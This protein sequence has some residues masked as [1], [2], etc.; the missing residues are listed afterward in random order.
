MATKKKTKYLNAHQAAPGGFK[1][2]NSTWDSL[3]ISVCGAPAKYIR[4]HRRQ[5]RGDTDCAIDDFL[6]ALEVEARRLLKD[7]AREKPAL[8]QFHLTFH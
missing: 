2:R 4:G 1:A 7:R 3:H 6:A 5:C 8:R